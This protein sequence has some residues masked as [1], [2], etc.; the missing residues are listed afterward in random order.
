VVCV[1]PLWHVCA[2]KAKQLYSELNAGVP[3]P[4]NKGMRRRDQLV[5]DEEK[6][7]SR[8]FRRSVFDFDYWANHRSTS[9]YFFHMVTLP[10]SRIIRSLG[11]PIA[12]CMGVATLICLQHTLCQ[13]GIIPAQFEL[14]ALD[15]AP[16]SLTSF[17]LSLLLVFRTNSSYGRF[18]E[19][20]K[21]WGLM[22][23]RSRDLAR[24]AVSYF[25]SKDVMGNSNPH[26]KAT[27]ARWTVVF[28]IALKCHLRP[29][30][31]LKGE[32]GKLLAEEELDLLMSAEHKVRRHLPPLFSDILPVLSTLNDCPCMRYAFKRS[33]GQCLLRRGAT[34]G[35]CE[36]KVHREQP[37]RLLQ[38]L[39]CLQVMS[40]IIEGAGINDF[41]RLQMQ[42]NVTTF[43]DILGGCERL[44]RT[45]IPVSYT[46]HTSRFLLI[47]LTILPLALYA[48]LVWATVPAVG[49]IALLLLGVFL[50]CDE[51]TCIVHGVS[52][53]ERCGC[54]M[55]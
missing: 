44:L 22:L 3:P 37:V 41:Q 32:A 46:R 47:W 33:Q 19:A 50:V 53:S 51:M 54:Y 45:P 48:K 13:N 24:Q 7:I 30:E 49:F 39:L 18:D 4:P 20:R 6:E 5:Y 9:R 34:S 10:N 8:T 29:N 52:R 28:T 40:H 12:W 17:A 2:A 1:S 55:T 27:F 14:G 26:A 31:D 16:V 35:L 15:L 21:M 36:S 23:N 43:E 25:P 38:V 42:Q 11:T